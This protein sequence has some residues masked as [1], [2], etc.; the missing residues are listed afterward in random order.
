MIAHSVIRPLA[1]VLLWLISTAVSD[2]QI[3]DRGVGFD[4]GDPDAPLLV[5]EFADFGCAACAQ[6]AL[7]T[8]PVI[9]ELLID[10]GHVRWRVIPF[11]LGA[12]KR[13]RE[14]AVASVCASEQNAFWRFHDSLFARR[15]EWQ[16]ARKPQALFETLAAGMDL[17]VIAFSQ[18]Y[19]SDETERYVKELRKVARK[20]GVRGTPT[21]FVGERKLE[22]APPT[23]DFVA[24]LTPGDSAAR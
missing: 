11:E 3:P 1:V 7:E 5:V 14:A 2:E 20:S 22:G 4:R 6:F 23:Q 8:F 10:S 17:D 21:F 12:F 24:L 15:G 16:R 9:D 19:E 13:S 18:C